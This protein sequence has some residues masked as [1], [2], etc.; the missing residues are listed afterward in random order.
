MT[1]GDGQ[2]HCVPSPGK[3]AEARYNLDLRWLWIQPSGPFIHLTLRGGEHFW[4]LTKHCS[5]RIFTQPLLL[6]SVFLTCNNNNNK[7]KLHLAPFPESWKNLEA[8]W[9]HLLTAH[10]SATFEQGYL[11][12]GP[13]A[14]PTG[15]LPASG[16][17]GSRC[18]SRGKVQ[19]AGSVRPCVLSR[20]SLRINW[21]LLFPFLFFSF[22]FFLFFFF[23][24][25]LN[26]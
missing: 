7:N 4:F 2:C 15:A 20:S 19:P 17:R 25:F 23:S 21:L 11:S 14:P 9:F 24:L 22:S 10:P 1:L 5:G 26:V 6:Q 3:P 13:A 18:A 16:S 8:L 12:S